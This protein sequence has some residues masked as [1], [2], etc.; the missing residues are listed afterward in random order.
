MTGKASW[1]ASE[2]LSYVTFLLNKVPADCAKNSSRQNAC[3]R[4]QAERNYTLLTTCLSGPTEQNH[5]TFYQARKYHWPRMVSWNRK[6][7]HLDPVPV[8]RDHKLGPN[9]HIRLRRG[10]LRSREYSGNSADRGIQQGEVLTIVPRVWALCGSGRTQ[11]RQGYRGRCW[12]RISCS[13]TPRP[14]QSVTPR[15][16][17]PDSAAWMI[18]SNAQQRIPLSCPCLY[19]YSRCLRLFISVNE[20]FMRTT[21][22]SKRLGLCGETLVCKTYLFWRTVFHSPPP[23]QCDLGLTGLQI[24]VR[25]IQ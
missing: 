8:H 9:E 7:T 17:T 11:Y 14:V 19:F 23:G 10:E 3:T 12:P 13:L 21:V 1:A 24:F 4:K 20:H 18:Q 16:L 5:H 2:Y 6:W 22:G 25:G 15:Q